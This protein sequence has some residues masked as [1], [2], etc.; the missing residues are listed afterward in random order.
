MRLIGEARIRDLLPAG[1]PGRLE[2][3][4]VVFVGDERAPLAGD[5]PLLDGRYLVICDNLRAVAR[6]GADLTRVAANDVVWT[7]PATSSVGYEDI[8]RDP[9]T[10]H[11]FLLIE[12]ERRGGG[13]E[14]GGGRRAGRGEA[15]RRNGRRSGRA[16]EGEPL[17]QARVEEYDADLNPIASG[18]L[19]Y[20]LARPNKGLEGLEL[21]RR[22]NDVHLLGLH[23]S[24]GLLVFRQ[25]RRNWKHV[26]AV[27]LPD[28]LDL[29]DYSGISIAG[30][31]VA[32]ISQQSATLWVGEL[33]PDT[34]SVT[35]PG[36]TYRF[37]RGYCTV[38]GVCWQGLS[39]VVVVSDRSKRGSQ[40]ASCRAKEES[41]HLFT[42]DE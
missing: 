19:E 14:V 13:G 41:L 38:E 17:F 11:V 18:W 36:S 5:G 15:G 33:A 24:G 9:S 12:S 35:G 37:P 4:G 32:L 2:A 34:W 16:A 40:P 29:A 31:R 27:D 6:I 23:E 25:G 7:P 28:D 30:R 39:T 3:S 22:D 8:A 26:A 21:V 10:G 1:S 42:I 20:P